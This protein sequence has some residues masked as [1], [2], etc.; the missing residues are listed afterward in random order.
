MPAIQPAKLKIQIA[1]L[2]ETFDQ[3]KEFLV[4]LSDFLET[5]ADRTRKQGFV[6]SSAS[7]LNSL[8]IPPQIIH[9]LILNLCEKANQSPESTLEICNQLWIKNYSEYR[10]IAAQLLSCLPTEYKPEVLEYIERW[11]TG[12]F[13]EKTARILLE[14]GLTV[15]KKDDPE[16]IYNIIE[17]W[18]SSDKAIDHQY[19][20]ILLELLVRDMT[21]ENNPRAIRF[22]APLI[23]QTPREIRSLLPSLISVLIL[24]DP[25][26]TAY[27]LIE[28]LQAF[29]SPDADWL[30]RYSIDK[31]PK[32]IQTS[33]REALRKKQTIDR[34]NNQ[35]I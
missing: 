35:R 25:Q 10:V 28:G 29:E 33:L 19:G 13:D 1:A 20:I 3:P 14:Q 21:F 26:E 9:Q 12:H 8:G 17:N 11:R 2:V 24:K 7:I 4:Q 22:I 15:L 23:R 18:L 30:I 27:I 31:F 34:S 16:E 5:Y 32:E 6:V